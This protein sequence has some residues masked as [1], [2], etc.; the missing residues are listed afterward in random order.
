MILMGRIITMIE[1]INNIM[2]L[3]IEKENKN[4]YR[5]KNYI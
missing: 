1:I 5:K 3:I 4:K 2:I